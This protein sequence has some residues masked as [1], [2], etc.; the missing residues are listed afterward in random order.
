LSY[1]SV[2]GIAP[3][4]I[5][6]INTTK[7]PVEV[8][9]IDYS[10]NRQLY[11]RLAPSASYLQET[12]L[13]HPWVIKDL[14]TGQDIVGFLPGVGEGVAAIAPVGAPTFVADSAICWEY[15]C[16]YPNNQPPSS[17]SINEGVCGLRA[18]PFAYTSLP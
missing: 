7:D 3:T 11:N 4:F 9:W 5:K 2:E 8:D 18:L 16:R 10:G 14:T 13:T 17:S 6:F 1:K 15:Y 12:Y